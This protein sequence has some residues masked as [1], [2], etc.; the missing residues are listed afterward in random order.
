MVSRRAKALAELLG[1]QKCGFTRFSESVIE[2]STILQSS[3]GTAA[4]SHDGLSFIDAAECK[5]TSN[6]ITSPLRW[7]ERDKSW[8][9][10][11]CKDDI[12]AISLHF[13]VL[14]N[15]II[16]FKMFHHLHYKF[17]CALYM[18]IIDK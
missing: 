18:K 16:L 14:L 13:S 1:V 10:Q 6:V 9:L 8:Y 12:N 4:I 15:Y 2:F 3:A 5:L 17:Y 11:I 7:S